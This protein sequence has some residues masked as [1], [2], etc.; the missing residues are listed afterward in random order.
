MV[1]H[2]GYE[3]PSEM[4][5]RPPD[6][7]LSD[8]AVQAPFSQ[9]NETAHGPRMGKKSLVPTLRSNNF[10][11]SGGQQMAGLIK[12]PQQQYMLAGPSIPGRGRDAKGGAPKTS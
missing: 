1:H 7:L 8:G 11:L 2:R 6:D 12:S 5:Q 4:G 9:Q 10:G 3:I